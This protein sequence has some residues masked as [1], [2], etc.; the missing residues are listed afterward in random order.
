MP[1]LATLLRTWRERALL[2]QDQLADLT[3]LGVHTVRRLESDGL[4]RPRGDSLRLLADALNLGDDERALLVAFAGRAG[5]DPAD[6]GIPRQLPADVAGFCG[7]G[8]HLRTPSPR[9]AAARPPECRGTSA[10][11]WTRKILCVAKLCALREKDQQRR[12]HR[13]QLMTVPKPHLAA[14]Q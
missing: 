3:D 10:G 4:R 9:R 1:A 13:D 11:A 2:T 6:S 14:A 8:E 5:P 12:R 7:R